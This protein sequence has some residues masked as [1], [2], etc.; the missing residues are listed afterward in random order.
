MLAGLWRRW[1]GIEPAGRGSLVP[2]A[3]KAAEP[4]RYP[5]TSIPKGSR[6]SSAL[7]P[8]IYEETSHARCLGCFGRRCGQ[9]TPISLIHFSHL[10]PPQVAVLPHRV[11]PH[12]DA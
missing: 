6:L 12:C 3:L 1:T 8:W 7:Y 2:T 11:A 4:T 5:D 10:S 9:K